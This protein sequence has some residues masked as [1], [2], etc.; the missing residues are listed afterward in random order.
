MGSVSVALKT[1]SCGGLAGLRSSDSLEDTDVSS[2]TVGTS[3]SSA[4]SS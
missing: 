1:K 4:W 3:R 2:S